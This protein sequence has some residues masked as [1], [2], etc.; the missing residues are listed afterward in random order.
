MPCEFD[1]DG[2]HELSVG[3][4]TVDAVV[5]TPITFFAASIY[6]T[7]TVTKYEPVQMDKTVFPW[8]RLTCSP[9]PCSTFSLDTTAVA[10]SIDFH[11]KYHFSDSTFYITSE[12]VVNIGTDWV[13]GVSWNGYPRYSGDTKLYP[14]QKHSSAGDSG[15]TGMHGG[16]P[17]GADDSTCETYRVRTYSTGFYN[18]GTYLGTVRKTK[19]E[20]EGGACNLNIRT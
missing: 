19:S 14:C 18:E 12:Q 9:D 17:G 1:G 20:M 13:L 4:S 3:A 15:T 7:K 10:S 16:E 2:K 6:N 8:P 11:I 5:F